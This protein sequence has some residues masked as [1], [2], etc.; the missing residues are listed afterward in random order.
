MTTMV[1][2]DQVDFA[3]HG[4]NTIYHRSKLAGVRNAGFC[5]KTR[6]LRCRRFHR[7]TVPVCM[8][9]RSWQVRVTLTSR[10]IVHD[11]VAENIAVDAKVVLA[12]FALVPARLTGAF[13][14]FGPSDLTCTTVRSLVHWWEWSQAAEALR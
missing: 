13:C 11:L 10:A 9:L 6:Y 5:N 8:I 4:M 1:M 12:A 7:V 3:M 2:F 14:S